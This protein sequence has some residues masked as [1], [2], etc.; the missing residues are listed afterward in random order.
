MTAIKNINSNYTIN[1]GNPPSA[2]TGT[3]TVNGN[4][5]I[6]G[7]TTNSQPS[8]SVS[9]FITVAAN[10]TGTITDMGLIA[11]VNANTFAGLR[12]DATTQAWQISPS[13]DSHG[14]VV[15]SAYA[16]I[17]TGNV[18]IGGI[19]TQ[20]QFNQANTLGAS[21]N[22]TFDYVNN[23]LSVIGDI[24]S[25]NVFSSSRI[26]GN[27]VYGNAV[28]AITFSASG[29]VITGNIN[30]PL[31]G[32]INIANLAIANTIISSTSAGNLVS[33][34]GTD[35]LVLPAGNTV[36]RPS[37][38]PIGTTRF[39]TTANDVETYNGTIWITGNN[40]VAII[41]DQQITPDGISTAYTLTQSSTTDSVIVSINGVVQLPG[42]AYVV[43]GTTITFSSAPL[44]TDIIDIRTIATQG[45]SLQLP[46]YNVTQALAIP[47]PSTGQ[48]IYV[49]NGNAGAPSLAVYD[50]TSWKRVALGATISA[51]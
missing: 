29:N 14:N 19:D 20:V 33:I 37:A 40:T 25:V 46:G 10:N 50:G 8:V 5:V 35:G 48:L 22:F 34:A 47:S 12:F 11:Q 4:L 31:S 32:T 43:S 49:S 28:S 42:V 24:Y 39:N 44:I 1:L 16:N 26:V 6:T 15:G 38:P 2:G 51:T 23:Q 45:Q 21:P 18:Q 7:S 13:V 17:A 9:P 27:T 41:A 3:L 36:Q 30:A